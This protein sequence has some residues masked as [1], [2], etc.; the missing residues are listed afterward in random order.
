MLRSMKVLIQDREKKHYL[1]GNGRWVASEDEADDFFTLRDAHIIAVSEK[2][3]N[4]RIVLY[5]PK[6]RLPD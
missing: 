5:A 4:F 6:Q 2:I 1:A 3:Q